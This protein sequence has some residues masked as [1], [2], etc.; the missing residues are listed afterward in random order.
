M[1]HGGA[2]R[3]SFA[4]SGRKENDN[5]NAMVQSQMAAHYLVTTASCLKHRRLRRVASACPPGCSSA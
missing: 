5:V 1:G 4:P 2:L 3:A